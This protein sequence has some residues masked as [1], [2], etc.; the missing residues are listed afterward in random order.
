MERN[1][2]VR[3]ATQA[4]RL[5]PDVCIDSVEP[6]SSLAEPVCENPIREALAAAKPEIA[7]PEQG[8]I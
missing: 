2:V 4:L 7:N 8:G 1:E 3:E 6:G 5:L